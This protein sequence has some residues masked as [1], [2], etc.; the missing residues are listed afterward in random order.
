MLITEFIDHKYW[1]AFKD[2]LDPDWQ[3]RTTDF[4]NEIKRQWGARPLDSIELYEAETWINAYR[5]RFRTPVSPNKLITRAKHLGETAVRWGVA[6]KNPFRDL[7]KKKEPEHKFLPLDEAQRD[8]LLTS[9]GGNLAQYQ[10]FARYTGGRIRSLWGLK[11]KHI[12][13]VK[14]VLTFERTKNGETYIIPL[15]PELQHYIIAQ[16]LLHGD[17][18]RYVLY[19]YSTP[20][21]VSRMFYRLK[22][23]LG[24]PFRFH[25]FRH[26]VGYKVKNPIL[27]QA[28]LGH[29]DKKTS[30]RYMHTDEQEVRDALCNVFQKGG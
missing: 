24:I 22:T 27:V 15:V 7:R 13:M 29:K 5:R 18:E 8:A 19:H 2:N 9:C 20:R 3:R 12:D 17:P 6:S 21:H 30:L 25:D 28:I 23:K 1:P 4:L 10:V 14:S 16:Q 11:E 26:S